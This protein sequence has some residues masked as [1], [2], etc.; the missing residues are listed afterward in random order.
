[1]FNTKN[2]T[3]IIVSAIIAALFSQLILSLLIPL[4]EFMAFLLNGFLALILMQLL[5]NIKTKSL[6]KT[7]TDLKNNT[8]N[9][10]SK[11]F[12]DSGSDSDHETGSVKW[13]DSSKGYGFITRDM[14]EDIFVHF[15]SIK[16]N[17]YRSLREGQAVKFVVTQG[18]KGPQAEDIHIIK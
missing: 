15:R 8:S 13:F 16:G 2:I 9:T 3:I 18:S 10:V 7:I 1:M 11:K 4:T 6:Q 17:G 12:S 5:L 14:G